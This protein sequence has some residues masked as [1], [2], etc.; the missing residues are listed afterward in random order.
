MPGGTVADAC[1]AYPEIDAHV[2]SKLADARGTNCIAGERLMLPS[3]YDLRTIE[4]RY[5]ELRA[6][7]AAYRMAKASRPTDS[8][9]TSPLCRLMAMIRLA[10]FGHA[11]T[12]PAK[13]A[14]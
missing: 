1:S 10:G 7:A 6:E 5:G 2:A 9:C 12:S 3:E 4:H 11:T 8:D 13:A 14:A